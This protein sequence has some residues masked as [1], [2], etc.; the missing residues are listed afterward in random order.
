MENDKDLQVRSAQPDYNR[1]YTVEEYHTWSEDFRAELYDG[2]LVV[3]EQPTRKHQGISRNLILQLG[4]FLKGKPCKLYHAPFGVRLTM[5]EESIFEP[6]IV[7]VCD[8]SILT[9]RGCTGAPDMIIEILSPSTA[10][11]DKVTKFNKYKKAGVKEYWIVDQEYS[12][13]EVNILSNNEYIT[14][15]YTDEDIVPVTIL[16]GCEINLAEVFDDN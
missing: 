7:V 12:M 14:R 15:P 9:E 10:R 1:L 13:V 16:K 3:M 8:E 11:R 2:E 5:K 6:D 4:N